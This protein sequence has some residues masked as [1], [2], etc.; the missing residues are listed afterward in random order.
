MSQFSQELIVPSTPSPTVNNASQAFGDSCT[1]GSSLGD[2]FSSMDDI[3]E[4]PHDDEAM[5][6][7][8]SCIPNL[9]IKDKFCERCKLD[10]HNID[11]CIKRISAT[12]ELL[13]D[14]QQVIENRKCM[15]CFSCSKPGHH[16]FDCRK[17]L[18][19][20]KHQERLKNNPCFTCGQLGHWSRHCP[21]K[22]SVRSFERESLYRRKL[23]KKSSKV[24]WTSPTSYVKIV[25]LMEPK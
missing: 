10:N 5:E 12:G 25:F 23:I 16:R 22:S 18:S 7:L 6:D 20:P 21:K 1:V 17:Y 2:I 24:T 3:L 13:E 8:T 19:S 15:I 9:E 14:T 11:T 4:E